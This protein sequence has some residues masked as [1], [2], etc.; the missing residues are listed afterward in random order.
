MSIMNQRLLTGSMLAL[1]APLAVAHPGQGMPAGLVSGVVHPLTGVDHLLVMLMAGLFIG[2]LAGNRAGLWL[3]GFVT[4]FVLAMLAGS[5]GAGAVA[6]GVELLLAG[7]VVFAGLAWLM[8]TPGR[9]TLLLVAGLAVAGLHGYVHGLEIPLAARAA[10]MAGVTT[11][12][13]AV[14]GGAVLLGRLALDRVQP[15][16][17]FRFL[18]YGIVAWGSALILAPS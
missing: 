3:A 9:H 15:D 17:R 18:G 5:Q 16:P 11:A 13:L 2:R 10:W 14:T 7:S 6:A 12:M 4:A 8:I 1:F